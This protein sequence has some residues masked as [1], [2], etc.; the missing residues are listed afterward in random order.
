MTEK[1]LS[2]VFVTFNS[3]KV[4]VDINCISYWYSSFVSFNCNIIQVWIEIITYFSI[5]CQYG[6]SSDE[7]CSIIRNWKFG[8]LF[9]NLR[10]QWYIFLRF[11][12]QS[13]SVVQIWYGNDVVRK[14]NTAVFDVLPFHGSDKNSS[15]ST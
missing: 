11:I 10:S 12:S 2:Q 14:A 15:I 3:T 7:R 13:K 8:E 5:C 4:H 6:F 9:R 1:I